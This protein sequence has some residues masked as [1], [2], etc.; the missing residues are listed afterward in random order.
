M[1]IFHILDNDFKAATTE[2]LHTFYAFPEN[3]YI[4]FQDDIA[5]I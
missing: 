1:P 4:N 3:F 2:E 5:Y